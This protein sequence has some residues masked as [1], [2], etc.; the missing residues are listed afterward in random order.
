MLR[1]LTR[2]CAAGAWR[3]ALCILVL[4]ALSCEQRTAPPAGTPTTTAP[5][6]PPPVLQV[7]D[8]APD[9]TLPGSDGRT[10]TLASFRG[11]QPVVLAWFAKA[12]TDG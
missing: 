9:F 4:L 6:T 1:D 8:P 11:R 5:Q 3:A 10:Y 2:L 7:G 12:F